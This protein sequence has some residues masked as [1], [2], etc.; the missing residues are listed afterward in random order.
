MT[1]EKMDA[2][3]C[4]LAFSTFINDNYALIRDLR[5]NAILHDMFGKELEKLHNIMLDLMFKLKKG[6]DE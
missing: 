2:A 1:F 6:G 3:A 4:M 5:E